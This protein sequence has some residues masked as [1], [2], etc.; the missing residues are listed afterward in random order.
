M[1]QQQFGAMP[2]IVKN[3]IIV[4]ALVFLATLTLGQELVYNYGCK[5]YVQHPNFQPYQLVTAMFLHLDF[6]HLFFN[7]L[8]LFFFGGNVERQLGP[9]RFLM[10]YLI[11]GFGANVLSLTFDYLVA[12]QLVLELSEAQIA[13]ARGIPTAI[14]LDNISQATLDY[15]KI[16]HTYGLGASGATYGVLFAFAA[17]NMDR[18]I[19]LLIPPIPIK[20]QYLALGFATLEFFNQ[21][22]NTSSSV[23]HFV[24]LSGGAIALILI[25]LWRKRGA[26]F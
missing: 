7:M 2:D 24:H 15:G 6:W 1:L 13:Y 26:P 8:V 12:Q 25:T 17:V 23:G 22:F 21:V 11:T 3:L 9:G 18:M 20:A 5:F 19:Q 14:N 10:L 4:N 16:W